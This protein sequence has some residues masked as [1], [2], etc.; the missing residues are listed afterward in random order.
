ML[1]H[2]F[3]KNNLTIE[4]V[5][6]RKIEEQMADLS[7]FYIDTLSKQ[8]LDKAIAENLDFGG[9]PEGFLYMGQTMLRSD[10][11]MLAIRG[12][13][14]QPLDESLYDKVS[15]YTAFNQAF[16]QNLQRMRQNLLVILSHI[17]YQDQ[18]LE[19]EADFEE[20][21]RNP[22]P[23]LK[24]LL[25]RNAVRELTMLRDYQQADSY[26]VETSIDPHAEDSIK[27]AVARVDDVLDEFL[28]YKLVM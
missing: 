3:G 18:A 21:A 10:V 26:V 17:L 28:A 7:Q 2:H 14:L 5:A 12:K 9:T 13:K 25:S 4:R 20:H 22:F 11:N 27:A 16:R 1:T 24:G 8:F 23:V 15:Q 19:H 6:W